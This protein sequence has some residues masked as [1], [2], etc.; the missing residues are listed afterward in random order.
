MFNKIITIVFGS[1]GLQCCYCVCVYNNI[2]FYIILVCA[3]VCIV[4]CAFSI[5]VYSISDLFF[6]KVEF[7]QYCADLAMIMVYCYIV[8]VNIMAGL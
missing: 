6:M 3:F 8:H 1:F 7:V 2:F 5:R 4:L